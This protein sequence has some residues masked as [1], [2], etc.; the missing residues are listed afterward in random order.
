MVTLRD[1]VQLVLSESQR[2]NEYLGSLPSEDWNQS[3]ACD[4]WQ[5]R[6]V[7]GHLTWAAEG[8]AE[9]ISRGIQG[10]V[11]PWRPPGFPSDL[12]TTSAS[13]QDYIG[14]SAIAHREDLGDQLLMTFTT[15]NDRL[16]QLFGGLTPE[17]WDKPCG[18]LSGSRTPQTF[19]AGR[20]TEIAI[21]GWDI[22]SR[23]QPEAALSTGSLPTLMERVAN[24]VAW[25][26]SPGPKLS[27]PLRY[28]FELRG[29][30]ASPKDLVVDGDACSM[31]PAG[32]GPSAGLFRTDTSTFVLLMCGRL[33]V[34]SALADGRLV[35]EAG[36]GPSA[37]F[38][39]WFGAG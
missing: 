20:V 27:E 31:E 8:F 24:F 4:L 22:Q 18:F 6:D 30:G 11:T 12:A 38:S 32:D 17:D 5:V 10:D 2:L 26:F 21:H 14:R 15:S 29:P 19:M 28:R 16:N 9:A 13:L 37:E 7:V 36:Q 39:R 35:L 34:D 33:L 1:Q 3:S 23:F 25:S